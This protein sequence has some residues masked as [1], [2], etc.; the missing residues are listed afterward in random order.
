MSKL[1][2]AIDKVLE[3][4]LV[5]LM[6]IMVVVVTWQVATR[7]LLNSPSSFTEEL[8]TYL[9]IWI[10]LLGGAY[11]VRLGAHLGV[12]VLTHRLEGRNK[13]ISE[14]LI[15]SM[16]IFFSLLVFIIG[17]IRLVYVTLT[18]DQVSAALKI[19]IGYIYTVIPLSGALM[20]YYAVHRMLHPELDA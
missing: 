18:L 9:L 7:Y 10:S 3:Q 14:L 4:A 12:D 20:I 19:P 16:I 8:A 17:G 13:R 2:A 5:W 11:G 15:Y 6:A 1:T